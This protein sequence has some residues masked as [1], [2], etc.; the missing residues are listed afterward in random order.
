VRPRKEFGGAIVIC[1]AGAGLVLLGLHQH[2]VRVYY[3]AP[4]PL[5]SGSLP[6]SGQSLLPAASALAL[7]SLACLAAIIATRGWAR[8]VAGLV[9]A[10]LGVWTCA[11]LAGTISTANAIS[12][13]SGQASSGG[14]S[15]LVPGGNSAISGNTSSSGSPLI[16]TVS[17]VAWEYAGW[18]QAALAGAVIVIAI[19]IVTLWRGPGWPVM[20][21]RFDRPG[22]QPHPAEPAPAATAATAQAAAITPPESEPSGD[23]A[24][25]W[26]A[27]DR[28]EDLTEPAGAPRDEQ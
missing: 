1:V 11:V 19:G 5:P 9:L 16:G 7:A 2:W 21:A 22:Q 27:L 28:G 15:G 12:A 26:E 10:G 14:L 8:Q 6:V 20:S 17:N 23:A 3:K 18:R 24:E 4:A 25:L 13:V